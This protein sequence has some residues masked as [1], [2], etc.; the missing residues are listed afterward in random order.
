MEYYIG[1][2]RIITGGKR[3]LDLP[4][5]DGNKQIQANEAVQNLAF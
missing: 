1:K 3:V 5:R 2:V 4:I